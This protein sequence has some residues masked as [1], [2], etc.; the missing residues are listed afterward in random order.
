MNVPPSLPGGITFCF[1]KLVHFPK[2]YQHSFRFFSFATFLQDNVIFLD[3]VVKD[4]DSMQIRQRC[5]KQIIHSL[6]VSLPIILVSAAWFIVI[7]IL[8][9][10]WSTSTILYKSVS[11]SITPIR[12]GV[13]GW[14]NLHNILAS[15][16]PS[17]IIRSPLKTLT[18][19]STLP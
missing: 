14:C 3:I 16:F 19:T 6:D 4:P 11:S 9:M 7:G 12:P 2:V 5:Q 15:S 17:S 1:H 8:L 13:P 18:I 10:R